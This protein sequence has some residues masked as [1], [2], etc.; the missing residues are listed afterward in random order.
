MREYLRVALVDPYRGKAGVDLQWQS[1]YTD[2]LGKGT[3]GTGVMP[4]LGI[5]SLPPTSW[6]LRPGKVWDCSQPVILEH[7][8]Y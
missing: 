2:N 5:V 7:T 3:G 8:V 4:R 1:T 6:T